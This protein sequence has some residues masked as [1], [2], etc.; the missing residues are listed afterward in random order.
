MGKKEREIAWG[1]VFHS[2]SKGEQNASTEKKTRWRGGKCSTSHKRMQRARRGVRLEVKR[3]AAGFARGQGS[4]PLLH[5]KGSPP[6]GGRPP[7]FVMS[8]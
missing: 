3:K 5:Q 4:R 2:S 1:I 8:M 6:N 7:I